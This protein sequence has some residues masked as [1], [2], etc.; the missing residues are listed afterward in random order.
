[1]YTT[2]QIKELT[3]DFKKDRVHTMNR[4]LADW[5]NDMYSANGASHLV[6]AIMSHYLPITREI[7]EKVEF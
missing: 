3:R 5:G 7:A 6:D 4:I 1:M 2:K